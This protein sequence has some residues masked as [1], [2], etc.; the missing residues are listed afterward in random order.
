MVNPEQ[1]ISLYRDMSTAIYA[2][3]F[4]ASNVLGARVN[5]GVD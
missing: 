4:F 2:I 5:N 1:D 3:G